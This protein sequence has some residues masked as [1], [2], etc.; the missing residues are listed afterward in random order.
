VASVFTRAER[1]ETGAAWRWG[2]GAR[3]CGGAFW[4]AIPVVVGCCSEL[5]LCR[6]GELCIRLHYRVNNSC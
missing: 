5:A 4:G 1:G 3:Y 2:V 6:V